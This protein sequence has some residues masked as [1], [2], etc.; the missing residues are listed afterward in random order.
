MTEHPHCPECDSDST[1]ECD[2]S[3]GM[4]LRC[5]VCDLVWALADTDELKREREERDRDPSNR[6]D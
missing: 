1:E 5:P 6:A 2:G 3:H 4:V